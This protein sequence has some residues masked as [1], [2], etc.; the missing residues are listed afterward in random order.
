MADPVVVVGAGIA[1]MTA[2]LEVHSMGISVIV[3]DRL[4]ILKNN[5]YWSG[6]GT[7]MDK[8][9]VDPE[10]IVQAAMRTSGGQADEGLWQA[11]A[12][13]INDSID[14]LIK[15]TGLECYEQS[16]MCGMVSERSRRHTRVVGQGQG[17]VAA[18]E[19]E[20]KTRGIPIYYRTRATELKKD[21]RGRIVGLWAEGPQGTLEL[22]S[23]AVILTCGGFQGDKAMVSQ[24]IGPWLTKLKL[25]GTPLNAGDG[26]IM[27]LEAGAIMTHTDQWHTSLRNR[28]RINPYPRLQHGSIMVNVDG[29]RFVDEVALTKND[30]SNALA[31][32]PGAS[33][34]V[35]FD[36]GTKE[37]MAEGYSIYLRD[38]IHPGKAVPRVPVAGIEE[39]EEYILKDSTMVRASS[40]EELAEKLHI[41]YS[42]LATTIADY[43]QAIAG[44]PQ[45]QAVPRS[46]EAYKLDQP[47]FYGIAVHSMLNCTL[48]GLKI[49]S[50]A[51]VLHRD[52]GTIPGLYA[53]G[54]IVGG[55]FHDNYQKLC[56]Y[57]PVCLVMGR[58]AGLNAA[59]L[60]T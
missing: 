1:G 43:H 39:V 6:G 3:L 22:F 24:H 14:W 40:L 17:V 7:L 44:N 11:F 35:L 23:K 55:F 58:I 20:V 49:D 38:H 57:L 8:F 47:P 30:V 42:N 36:E 4:K 15:Q 52:R 13:H 48:G 5:T 16:P 54:E 19:R 2:A 50:Q 18:M 28:H 37:H 29:R 56:G 10:A 26:H 33:G 59:R 45:H 12:E 31:R 60:S 32:Q 53:A 41:P 21:E 25:S 34:Y 46:G 27:A 9:E 51:R